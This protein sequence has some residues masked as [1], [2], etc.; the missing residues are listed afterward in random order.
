[1]LSKFFLDRPVFAWVIAIM[2]MVLGGLAIYTLPI[3]QYPPLSPPSISVGCLYTGA[4]AESVEN[5]VTQIIEQQMTGLDKM[6][7]MSSYSDSAGIS[8]VSLTFAPG[9]D[10]DLAW[11]KVQNKLQLAMARLPD[12]VQRRGVRV[13]KSTKNYLMIVGLISED[14]SMSD[15]DLRD[16]AL[17]VVQPVLARVPGVGEAEGFGGEYAMRIWFDP[18]KLTDYEL[19]VGDLVKALRDYNVEIAGG[20][21]GGV[22]AV[23]GQRL[24][25]SI[26]VQSMLTTPEEFANIPVRINPDGSIIRIKDIGRVELGADLEDTKVFFNRGQPAAGLTI[27]QEPGA[28]A[29]ETADAIK[30]KMTELS[31]YFPKGMK[32]TYPYDTTPFTRVAIKEVLKTLLEAILLVFLV[33]YLFM[34]NMRA[35]LIPTIAVPVVL[36]GTFAALLFFGYSINMLTMFAMVLA[37]GLLVDDAIVVVENVERLM[38]EEGLSPL[39]AAAKSMEQITPA[40]IGIGLVLSAVFGPMAFFSGST[41]IIYRQFSVTI[42]TAMLLS[43]VVALIL[44]PVLCATFLKPV[45]KGHE[46]AEGGI[47]FLRPFFRWFDR[48]FFRIR[49]G[50]VKLVDKSLT[51]VAR[52]LLVYFLIVGGM[53][54]ILMRIPTGYLPDED[55]GILAIMATLPS[56]ST[57]EQTETLMEKTRNY[58]LDNEKKAVESVMT[59]AGQ[60]MAG[61][62]QNVGAAFIRLR[63]W[64]LRESRDLKADAIANRAMKEVMRYKEASVF[65]FPPPAIIELGNAKG[66]DFELQDLG[67]AGHE[68]L[69]EARNQLLQMASQDPRLT[70]VRHNGMDDV[71]EYRIDLDWEKAGSLGVPIAS[72]QDTI[73]AAFG[74][75]Y[76]NDFIKGGRI[77]HVDIQADAPHRMLPE[78]LKNLYVRNSQGKMVPYSSFATGHWI[79]GSP[80]RERYNSFPSINIWG[81]AAPGR[82]SGEAMRAMEELAA[83]LPREFGYDWTGLSYQERQ[84]RTQVAPLYAFSILVIFLCVAALYESWVIPISILMVLPLGAFG[85]TITTGMRGLANDIYFQIGLLTTLGLTTKNAILIIQFAEHAMAKGMG[86]IDAILQGVKLRFR[87]IIMTSLAFG[88]G[89]LPLAITSGAGASAQNS[90]GTSVLGGMVTAT[91]LVLIFTPLFYVL[92]EKSFGKHKVRGNLKSSETK[93]P[94]DH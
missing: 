13:S 81:E 11:S 67:G 33:M 29:L 19:A 68:K 46:P 78:D 39:E 16:Y 76:I 26:I 65:V 49:D 60:D 47:W 54:F 82:S 22:P 8:S 61:R 91:V 84:G 70:R 7:Y 51:Q 10:P 9:T 20:Q 43:V 27:R 50:Y 40:L 55:Q 21:F 63:D 35:T 12:S 92:I 4:S 89:I 5:S 23:K 53:L 69:M 94:E 74:S 32:V 6:L 44:T 2:I 56:G 57:L 90:I 59:V 66:F 77:K 86:L 83:K 18:Q 42:I 31:H 71:T 62:S 75:N 15:I 80:R 37:I 17:S 41:G 52:Y 48:I 64:H 72:I 93:P 73:S 25:A 14:G 79:F 36:L 87:P 24:N 30:A 88:F 38:T 34:G 85:S 58:F 1:M 45:P 28:N 3:A